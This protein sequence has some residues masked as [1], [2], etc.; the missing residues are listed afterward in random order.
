MKFV[1]RRADG[2]NGRLM[3]GDR[4][5]VSVGHG[6]AATAA[7]LVLEAGGNAVD[8]GVAAGL[9]L[10]RTPCDIGASGSVVTI[11]GLGIWPA[12]ASWRHFREARAGA[13]SKGL[14]STSQQRRRR[15]VTN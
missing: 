6:A 10:G 14:L 3:R 13:I 12:T 9:V 4:H 5:M 8:A 1:E 2:G 15:L 7:L 11:D